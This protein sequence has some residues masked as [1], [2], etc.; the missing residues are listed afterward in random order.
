MFDDS[1]IKPLMLLLG[2]LVGCFLS[3]ITWIGVNA[4]IRM[5]RRS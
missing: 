4:A 5:W 3:S 1:A 2:F